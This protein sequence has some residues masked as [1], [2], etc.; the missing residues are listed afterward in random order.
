MLMLML[1]EGCT[2]FTQAAVVLKINVKNK[3]LLICA[4]LIFLFWPDQYFD[5]NLAVFE[6]CDQLIV[7]SLY[8][9]C[10]DLLPIKKRPNKT[11][12]TKKETQEAE[13]MV[14]SRR[15]WWVFLTDDKNI[16]M[17][18]LDTLNINKT[19]TIQQKTNQQLFWLSIHHF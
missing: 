19:E 7:P 12:E 16:V 1:T 17:D 13:V 14:N 9:L 5:R 8:D 18:L 2:T 6:S 11:I 10:Y 15:Y 3:H 4:F